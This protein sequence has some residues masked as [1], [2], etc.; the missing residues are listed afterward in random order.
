[1][2]ASHVA[3]AGKYIGGGRQVHALDLKRNPNSRRLTLLIEAF[4]TEDN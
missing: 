2:D 1:M 4:R 3:H